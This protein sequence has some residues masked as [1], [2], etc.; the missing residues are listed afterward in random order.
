MPARTIRADT[1]RYNLAYVVSYVHPE[2]RAALVEQEAGLLKGG[3]MIVYCRQKQTVAG[4]AARLGCPCYFSSYEDK[5]ASMERFVAAREGVIVATNA[6]GLGIDVPNVRVVIHYDCPDTLVSYAQES[7]RAG[8]DGQP[9]RCI[10]L[11]GGPNA[12]AHSYEAQQRQGK[13]PFASLDAPQADLWL[14]EYIGTPDRP[15]CRRTTLS[16]YLDG[17]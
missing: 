6:L 17:I 2:E 3:K 4:L 10:L 14:Q 16:R 5:K 12:P 9:A 13:R 15:A 11:V 7:G 1:T 8:R